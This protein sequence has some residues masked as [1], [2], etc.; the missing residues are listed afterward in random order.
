M[1]IAASRIA[2]TQLPSR[3]LLGAGIAAG[4]AGGVLW[5]ARRARRARPG[6]ARAQL[7]IN[8]SPEVCYRAARHFA[9][10][11][12]FLPALT[13]VRETDAGQ[14]TWTATQADGQPVQW[15]TALSEEP[16]RRLAWC[17]ASGAPLQARGELRIAPAPGG[18]GSEML[19]VLEHA[20]T[21]PVPRRAFGDR[22][23]ADALRRLR[24]WIECGEIA[25]TRGQPSGREPA[26]VRPA[27][28]AAAERLA[29]QPSADR[30]RVE[31]TSEL[32]FPASDA[33]GS[34]AG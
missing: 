24:M 5:V 30:D 21:A 28:R 2:R 13:A 23:A 12:R 33:P 15:Q 1:L 32:S 8:R 11:P 22:A 4:L 20:G 18:R 10:W 27:L 25:T 6:A 7:T 9:D 14:L 19:L 34:R 16:P 29:A 26:H 31:L 3:W 17:T